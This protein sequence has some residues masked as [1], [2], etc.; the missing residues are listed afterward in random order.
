[1]RGRLGYS[2][3]EVAKAGA[4][5]NGEATGWA[6]V[7]GERA[8]DGMGG[9]R[10][11]TSGPGLPAGERRER[12]REGAADRWG[13]VVKRGTGARSWA[14]W[15]VGGEGESGRGRGLGRIRPSRGGAGFSFSFFFFYFLFHISIFYFLFLF[16]S[17][18]FES[19]I[20]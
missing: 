4:R 1:V 20:C 7:G 5:V 10:D 3:G 2:G 18:S 16:I 6:V 19:T 13:Q 9:T 8:G 15:V 17:F 14:A 12:E 11:L